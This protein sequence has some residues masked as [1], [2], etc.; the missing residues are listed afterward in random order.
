MWGRAFDDASTLRLERHDPEPL[1]DA[2]QRLAQKG[3]FYDPFM[4]LQWSDVR[5]ECAVY[6]AALGKLRLAINTLD[7][8]KLLSTT[9]QNE[10]AHGANLYLA[11]H[12][13]DSAKSF[14]LHLCNF[15]GWYNYELIDA[16]NGQHKGVMF[17]DIDFQASGTYAHFEI[18]HE[19]GH[20]TMDARM[21]N[22][23]NRWEVGEISYRPIPVCFCGGPWFDRKPI[24]QPLSEIRAAFRP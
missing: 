15:P 3:G 23:D 12:R 4:E 1:S 24:L 17:S 19:T 2:E 9:V 20:L 5:R 16:F 7:P 6:Q 22:V 14:S 11:R 21:V 13:G 8:I 10:R 18:K